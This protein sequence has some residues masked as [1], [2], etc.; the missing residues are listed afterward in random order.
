MRRSLLDLA[1]ATVSQT[2]LL[3][4]KEGFS[5]GFF[6]DL[7][8]TTPVESSWN[9]SHLFLCLGISKHPELPRHRLSPWHS[10]AASP[11]GLTL[12]LPHRVWPCWG[13]WP[14]AAGQPCAVPM[15]PVQESSQDPVQCHRRLPVLHSGASHFLG[16]RYSCPGLCQESHFLPSPQ[17]RLSTLFFYLMNCYQRPL[18]SSDK[19]FL[20]SKLILL[21][22]NLLL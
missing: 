14:G 6:K 21:T 17:M 8:L 3:H 16:H 2:S 7:S 5:A 4:L 10:V 1:Q 18:R 11:S 15:A 13:Q 19:L 12:A 22:M 20:K 9:F